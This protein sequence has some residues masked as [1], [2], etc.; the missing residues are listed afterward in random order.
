MTGTVKSLSFKINIVSVSLWPWISQCHCTFHMALCLWPLAS[1]KTWPSLGSQGS[2]WLSCFHRDSRISVKV[3]PV[4]TIAEQNLLWSMIGMLTVLN[5]V[6]SAFN[7]GCT[8]LAFAGTCFAWSSRVLGDFF[9]CSST[10]TWLQYLFASSKSR[11]IWVP[12]LTSA[13]TLPTVPRN[14]LASRG[15]QFQRIAC[16]ISFSD[17]FR[18]HLSAR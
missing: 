16:T 17:I 15:L 2:P 4:S 12:I 9:L 6:C 13:L 11:S 8:T 18:F 5:V 1:M 14:K 10:F 3:L 7:T